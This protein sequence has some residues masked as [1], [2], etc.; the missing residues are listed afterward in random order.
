MKAKECCRKTVE[1][2]AEVLMLSL[3]V[4]VAGSFGRWLT[5]YA[6]GYYLMHHK[7]SVE[8]YLQMIFDGGVTTAVLLVVCATLTDG[9]RRQVREYFMGLI[10]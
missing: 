1:C 3:I 6:S 8:E 9:I 7:F 4:W 2:I 10:K 5:M